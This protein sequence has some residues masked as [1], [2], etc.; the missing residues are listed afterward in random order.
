MERNES[1]IAALKR[2]RATYVAAGDDDRV[3]QVD[4]SLKHY[5]YSDPQ[6][7]E[8]KERT[9][10]PQ[11]T[12]DQSTAQPAQQ[13]AEPGKTPARRA[14]G[15]KADTTDAAAAKPTESNGPAGSAGPVA[16]TGQ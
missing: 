16:P 11:Q 10:A 1:M 14:G 2:E 5:G 7:E 15:R 4:A 9:Q 6:A 3:R 8:P 13:A 12:A